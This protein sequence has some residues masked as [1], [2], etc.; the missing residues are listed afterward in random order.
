MKITSVTDFCRVFRLPSN[1]PRGYCFGGGK[2]VEFQLVDWFNPFGGTWNS[3]EV[4]EVSDEEYRK[5]V[6]K[7]KEFILSKE[8][9]MQFPKH[10]FLVLTDY[11]DAFLVE[12][13]GLT[14]QEGV[15]K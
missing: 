5:H 14:A 15:P 9:V 10:K 3:T 11:G 2:P 6:N 7:L 13:T 8:Y 12:P 4:K 1:Y